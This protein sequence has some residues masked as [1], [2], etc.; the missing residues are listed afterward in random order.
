[1][2][3][4][5]LSIAALLF[6]MSM[7]GTAAVAQGVANANDGSGMKG[8]RVTTSENKKVRIYTQAGSSV[9]VTLID[10][11]GTVLYRGA[12]AGKDA[13]VTA[14]N[15]KNL[16]DGQYF[17]TAGTDAW[18]MSQGMT[19]RGNAISIDAQKLQQVAQPTLTAYEK[20]KIEVALPATNVDMTNVTIYNA[21][22]Q[23]VYQ[24]TFKGAVRRFD[25]TSLPQ[26]AYTFVVGPDQKQFSARIDIR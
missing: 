21:E 7:T 3:Q 5:R 10:T 2:K 15:L 9:D 19:V 25:L 13:K 17:I 14:F 6:T 16:P 26:G 4:I 24:D 12:I 20:N 23:A 8:V 22:S 11:D 1:M 18:W